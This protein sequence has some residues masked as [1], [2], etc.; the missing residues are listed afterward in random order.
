MHSWC[1][2][3]ST[4]GWPAGEYQSFSSSGFESLL[5]ALIVVYQGM[6]SNF[7]IQII[8]FIEEEKLKKQIFQGHKHHP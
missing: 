3:L 2:P 7:E 8:Y 5:Y 1:L 4:H 6:E